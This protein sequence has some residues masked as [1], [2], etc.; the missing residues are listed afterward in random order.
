MGQFESAYV[1][2]FSI[3]E[4][5]LLDRDPDPF[6]D[7]ITQG[8]TEGFD[9]PVSVVSVI[10]AE[11]DRQFFKSQ[12]GLKPPWAERQETPLSHSFCQY[13][14]ATQ[15]PLVVADAR[16]HELVSCNLAIEELG[17]I[18]YLGVPVSAP[19]EKCVAALCA[20]SDQPRE[21]LRQEIELM[22]RL[23][24]GVSAHIRAQAAM[25]AGD[26]LMENPSKCF[27]N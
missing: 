14:V 19:D 9:V 7:D 5:G 16:E 11:G 25:L 26:W 1:R 18:A 24:D 12:T 3:H 23:A 4:I 21:W 6:L 15:S 13:V 22:K 27:G 2:G 10:D 8:I 17:V 20:I